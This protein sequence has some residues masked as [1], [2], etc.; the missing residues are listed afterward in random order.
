M[1]GE[2]KLRSEGMR[3]RDAHL[4]EWLARIHPARIQVVSRPEPWPRLALAR[5]R[6]RRLP[7]ANDVD[8]VS[9][10]PFVM[11]PASPRDRRRWWCESVKWLPT[12]DPDAT[13][14]LWNPIAAAALAQRGHRGPF[15][16]DLL[17]DWTIHPLFARLGDEIDEA[18]RCA[19]D[20]A[21]GVLANAEGTIALARRYGRD[22]AILV[23][24]GVDPERFSTVSRA[25]GPRTIVGY[26]GKLGSRL[27]VD[28]VV[29]TATRLCD[30]QFVFAGPVVERRVLRP[31]R[32][33]P[34]VDLLGDVHYDDYPHL[35]TTWDAAWI[36]HRVGDGEIG[37]DVIKTYEYRAAGLPTVSTPIVGADRLAGVRVVSRTDMVDCLGQLVQQGTRLDREP[38]EIPREHHWSE[39]A[40]VLASVAGLDQE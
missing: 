25:D 34:N 4:I 5:A 28:L 2:V 7:I 37:G 12:V 26:A 15:V 23:T 22:D 11:F 18:Y 32:N 14:L 27:D 16:V 8:L 3:T 33:L 9:P 19:F 21:D 38:T 24:N 1:H 39:K 29:D 17:D 35:L 30:V 13:V 40:R 6:H 31:L 20:R 36:P 10:E